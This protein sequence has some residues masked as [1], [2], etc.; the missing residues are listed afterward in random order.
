[1]SNILMYFIDFV[2]IPFWVAICANV[3]ISLLC[4]SGKVL[5]ILP[6]KLRK[7]PKKIHYAWF[8]C[9][10]CLSGQLYL[11]FSIY[12]L[13]FSLLGLF[14]SIYLGAVFYKPIS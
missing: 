10:A 13:D 12:N 4:E 3:W 5:D 14:L 2:Y 11:V 1:M 8:G 6:Y 9:S 7:L